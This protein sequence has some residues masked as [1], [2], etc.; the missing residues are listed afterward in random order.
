MVSIKKL[1]QYKDIEKIGK[2]RE[3]SYRKMKRSPQEKH[4]RTHGN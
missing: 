4:M 2:E 3:N 1:S